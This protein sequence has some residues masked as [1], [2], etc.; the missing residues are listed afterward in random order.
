METN[1]P[2][3]PPSALAGNPSSFFAQIIMSSPRVPAAEAVAARLKDGLELVR[4]VWDERERKERRRRENREERLRRIERVEWELAEKQRIAAHRKEEDEENEH[5]REG[6]RRL[7]TSFVDHKTDKELERVKQRKTDLLAEQDSEKAKERQRELERD[8]KT[9]IIAAGQLTDDLSVAPDPVHLPSLLSGLACHAHDAATVRRILHHVYCMYLV[10]SLTPSPAA[11]SKGDA[12]HAL[13]AALYE[14]GGVGLLVGALFDH[15]TQA[16]VQLDALLLL[17]FLC[18]DRS[19]AETCVNNGGINAITIALNDHSAVLPIQQCGCALLSL[20]ASHL[21]SYILHMMQSDGLSLL[22]SSVQK[23]PNDELLHYHVIVAFHHIGVAAGDH[24]VMLGEAGVLETIITSM[25]SFQASLLLQRAAVA[26]LACLCDEQIENGRKV[27]KNSGVQA[28]MLAVQRHSPDDPALLLSALQLMMQMEWHVLVTQ[29]ALDAVDGLS[30]LL[31]AGKAHLAQLEVQKQ[32]SAAIAVACEHS[33]DLQTKAVQKGVV[34]YLLLVAK[35]FPYIHGTEALYVHL[36]MCVRYLASS[37][38]NKPAL[39]SSSLITLLFTSIK[40]HVQSDVVA[41]HAVAA[42]AHLSE[43]ADEAMRRALVL[44]VS[45]S[46]MMLVLHVMECHSPTRAV[47]EQCMA[48]LF[49]LL[50]HCVEY[51]QRLIREDWIPSLLTACKD[52]SS[53][54]VVCRHAIA[55]FSL[56]SDSMDEKELFLRLHGDSINQILIAMRNHPSSLTLQVYSLLTLRNLTNKFD[57]GA[58]KSGEIIDVVLVKMR[59]HAASPLVQQ[60]AAEALW[61]LALTDSSNK[62]KLQGGEAIA[63]VLAARRAHAS[64][65]DVTHATN[66]LLDVLECSVAEE[67]KQEKTWE[68]LQ[69]EHIA[70]EV[71]AVVTAMR[72]QPEDVARALHGTDRLCALAAASPLAQPLVLQHLDAVFTALRLHP[73]VELIQ[74]AGLNVLGRLAHSPSALS[75][76]TSEGGIAAALTALDPLPSSSLLIENAFSLLRALAADATNCAIIGRVGVDVVLDAVRTREDSAGV[77]EQAGRLLHHLVKDDV[78]REAALKG[79]GLGVLTRTLQLWGP[80]SVAV[81]EDGA[82]A[83]KALVDASG[84]AAVGADLYWALVQLVQLYPYHD[85]IQRCCRDVLLRVALPPPAAAAPVAS[86]PM[87]EG[88]PGPPGGAA[89]PVAYAVAIPTPPSMT[90]SSALDPT[91]LSPTVS[92]PLASLQHEAEA[93]VEGVAHAIEGGSHR[94]E[95]DDEE[96]ENA[97]DEDDDDDED[98]DEREDD[99]DEKDDDD[100]KE[101]AER[102]PASLPH[103]SPLPYPSS[104]SSLSS[105][106]EKRRD[107]ESEVKESADEVH[108]SSVL[109][110]GN[111]SRSSHPLHQVPEADD[112]NVDVLAVPLPEERKEEH[113]GDADARAL[114]VGGGDKVR[115]SQIDSDEAEVSDASEPDRAST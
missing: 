81:A 18:A 56:L 2:P 49:N 12:V 1:G 60:Y 100:I 109:L 5:K 10:A 73:Y 77:A 47:I 104:S 50:R 38:V 29:K 16:G 32:C 96:D 106:D 88:P 85:A 42:L 46:G 105:S 53:S 66:G 80:R 15:P 8:E 11:P 108:S 90:E 83:I 40:L 52:H 115:M 59:T 76:I 34:E 92:A 54:E 67:G 103:P 99:A 28:T 61:N 21:P 112:G 25:Y 35:H 102:P 97:E 36:C 113:D 19:Y 23:H 17:Y 75:L 43:H 63:L 91:A 86:G 45:D 55:I 93:E 9:L 14:S 95:E 31:T 41:L 3:P 24:R 74:V 6:F 48:V 98:V 111:D 68:L 64:Q 27:S 7:L 65:F 69:Q 22:L 37:D 70:R 101:G 33:V 78:G 84:P 20:L 79:G 57:C 72:A 107:D 44:Q 71:D 4:R 58:V 30:V 39:S 114:H 87:A 89:Y 13:N 62:K 94:T 51:Q 82:G 110:V 26:S